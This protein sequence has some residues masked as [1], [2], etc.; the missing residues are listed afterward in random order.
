[1]LFPPTK[2]CTTP[3]CLNLN[4]LKNKDGLRKVV[5]FTLS[6]GACATYA[7]HLHCSQCKATYYNNYFVCNGLR[8]YYAGI[9]NAIQVGE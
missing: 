9:P 2:Q 7:V 1:T 5:L 8:T 3:G 6:D 4:L